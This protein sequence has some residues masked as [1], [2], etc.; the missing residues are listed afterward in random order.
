MDYREFLQPKNTVVQTFHY[1]LATN[2]FTEGLSNP[3]A[4]RLVSCHNLSSINTAWMHAACWFV[5]LKLNFAI[6]IANHRL[7]DLRSPK[8][9]VISILKTQDKHI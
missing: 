7:D 5:V 1:N 8:K 4:V 3:P 9:N 6:T 2:R